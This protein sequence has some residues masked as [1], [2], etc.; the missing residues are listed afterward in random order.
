MSDVVTILKNKIR[1]GAKDEEIKKWIDDGIL[2]AKELVA[3]GIL[4]EEKIERI[5][6]V[7]REQHLEN[8]RKGHYDGTK[9]RGLLTGNVVSEQDLLAL[10][11]FSQSTLDDILGK[12]KAPIS[13]DFGDWHDVPPLKEHR[14]DVFV[15]GLA[16][17][18]K[19]VFM[20]GLIFYAHKKGRLVN[21]IEYRVGARYT[22]N[23]ISAVHQKR[24]PP[25]TPDDYIQFLACDFKD[26]RGSK[27]PLTFLEMS[28]EI[29]TNIHFAK[30]DKINP[31]F[32]EYLKGPNQ[33]VIFL[34][35]DY[36][37]HS[38]Q[39]RQTLDITQS[40]RFEYIMQYFEMKGALRNTIAVCILVTKWDLCPN[41][42]QE[43]AAENFLSEEY[44]NLINLIKELR[45]KFGFKFEIFTFSLGEFNDRLDYTYNDR[46]SERIF[47]WLCSFTDITP[48]SS[49]K[50]GWF[51]RLFK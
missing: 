37:L 1:S 42:N 41:P 21:D 14:M 49:S 39:S 22:G 45:D 34:A 7:S 35:I 6:Y 20:S 13:V 25:R 16:G 12:P 26:D 48:Q 36:F 44:L 9:I 19:S 47:N 30:D 31:R 38:Y 3:E 51:S 28:G 46:D 2:N 11:I 50:G 15:L 8:I 17:S 43:H 5:Y 33:K 24:L 27:H 10:G 32:L 23:L 29:F 40:S 18:G 4:T